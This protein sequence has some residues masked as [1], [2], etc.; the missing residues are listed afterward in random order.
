MRRYL[1]YGQKC[2]QAMSLVKEFAH[3]FTP[4]ADKLSIVYATQT[5]KA[6]CKSKLFRSKKTEKRHVLP[7][8]IISDEMTRRILIYG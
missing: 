8:T 3:Y 1:L 7:A 5:T 6:S 2:F 4:H